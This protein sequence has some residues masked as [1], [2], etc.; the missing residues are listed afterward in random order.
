MINTLQKRFGLLLLLPVAVMLTAIG[1]AA[2]VYARDTLLSQWRE[3]TILKLQRAAHYVDMRL[4]RPKELIVIYQKAKDDSNAEGAQ[5]LIYEQL[6]SLDGVVAVE[7]YRQ[8]DS[9]IKWPEEMSQHIGNI[10]IQVAAHPQHASPDARQMVWLIA[11]IASAAGDGFDMLRVSLRFDY[12][13]GAVVAS[14]WWLSDQAFLI[15]NDGHML[16]GTLDNG[17]LRRFG[18]SGNALELATL[19]AMDKREFGTVI[20][21]D[22]HSGQISGFYKLSAAPWNLVIISP[23]NEIL[24]PVTRFSFYFITVGMISLTMI[25]LIM[26]LIVGHTVVGIRDVSNAAARVARGQFHTQLPVKTHDEVGELTVSFN[27]MIGQLKERMRLKASIN[28]AKE[29]QQHL[30]PEESLDFKGLDIASKSIYCDETGGDYYDYFKADEF[31]PGRIGIAVGDVSGHGVS[32]AL[33]MATVRALIRGRVSTP[34]PISDILVDVN[35]LLC[36]DTHASGD[37]MTLFFMLIDTVRHE[38]CWVRAGHDPA[39]LY[40]GNTDILMPMDGKGGALGIDSAM[41]FESCV[42]HG[43]TDR[44]VVVV[45]TDGVWET[46]NSEG[47]R[48]GKPRLHGLIRRHHAES[49]ATIIEHILAALDEFCGQA[50][51]MD[52]I[53][54]V[55]VKN[56]RAGNRISGTDSSG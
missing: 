29:V 55:V 51:Q 10:C 17:R 53:T 3:A 33:L 9:P 21:A 11:P 36:R 42:N 34:G 25:L 28:L 15:D 31:G 32:S 26:R 47:E 37:F 4:M 46:E 54:L 14:G 50:K 41:T 22:G 24:A 7:E 39:V 49:A 38:I 48:F 16:A 45:Y 20:G 18:E 23:A 40:D 52:D 12:L 44:H 35:R 56:H 1:V 2:Y 27:T 6:I 8:A 30:L 43:W 13:V 19:Q 5:A